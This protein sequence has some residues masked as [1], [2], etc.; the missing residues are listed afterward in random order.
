M[1]QYMYKNYAHYVE[2]QRSGYERK[3]DKLWARSENIEAI[4][5]YIGKCE[6]G[7]CHG[8]RGGQEVNWFRD[9]TGAQVI[10][11]EIG[12]TQVPWV[13][14]WDFNFPQENWVGAFDFVYSNAFDHAYDPAWTLAVWWEQVKKGGLLIIETDE[15][16]E[17]SGAISK[18][19]NPTDPTGISLDELHAMIED[20]TDREVDIIDLPVVTFGYRVALA[21]RK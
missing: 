20:V 3:K 4:A 12:D 13:I 2:S 11:T 21:V 14:Q 10:G 7:L 16:N 6:Y 15:R 5:D 19:V 1:K 8:V 18:K 17:H 9:F